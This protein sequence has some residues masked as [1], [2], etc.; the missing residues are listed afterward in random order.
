MKSY[1]KSLALITRRRFI[2]LAASF[3]ASLAWRSTSAR[4]S[5]ISWRERRDLYPQ[6]VASGD[7]HPDSVILWTRRPPSQ[8]SEARRLT[9]EIADDQAF[10]RVVA[11]A[12][13]DI[14]AEADWTCR[15]LAAGLKPARVYWYRFTDEG[16]F[17][18][19]VGR[20]ITAPSDKDDRAARFA[21]VSCQNAQQGA[22]TAYRRMIW[23]DEQRAADDQLGF[24]LHL[25]D[26]IYE[27]VW[28]PEDRPQG[29]YDRRLRDVARYPDGE[30]IT[31]FH[32]PT[33]V[34][35]YRAV[36]RGY[37]RDPDLQDAR[38]RWPFVCMWDNHEY[39][40]LGYQGIQVFGSSVRPAQTRKVA[41]NQAW[42]EYQPARVKKPG[43]ASL[44][45]FEPPHV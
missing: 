43:G 41:A 16:G 36:Y 22:S 1:E 2:E 26:F 7:P 37:L 24:V 19:R 45:T 17:G 8:N 42:W 34:G 12:R 21:F 32:V 25:G 35:D 15:V 44:E 38:A 10:R 4:D 5:R 9:V 33:T 14:S 6:G 31:D 39:S 18:S 11:S 28:Y 40:W 27:I 30:K 13:A 3:G 29:Y 23:E 20:T